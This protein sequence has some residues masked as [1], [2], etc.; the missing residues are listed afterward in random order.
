M[1]FAKNAAIVVVA[2]I[3]SAGCVENHKTDDDRGACLDNM[4]W[5]KIASDLWLDEHKQDVSDW[6]YPDSIVGVGNYIKVEPKCPA[7]GTYK[8]VFENR[9]G[10]PVVKVICS[11]SSDKGHVLP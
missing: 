10:E 11:M 3:L 6:N 8:V 4:R 9:N 7:G 2:V 1:K 5:L